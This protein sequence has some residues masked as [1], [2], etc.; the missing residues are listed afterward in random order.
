MTTVTKFPAM[1]T[2]A[3]AWT[4]IARD[5]PIPERDVVDGSWEAGKVHWLRADHGPG[6]ELPLECAVHHTQ[7]DATIRVNLRTDEFIYVIEGELRMELDDG[8]THRFVAGDA[9]HIRAGASGLWSYKAPF[10]EF[11]TVVWVDGGPAGAAR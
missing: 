1:S 6:F 3:G 11:V 5:V 10:R 7:E 8:S 2:D 9:L 4:S